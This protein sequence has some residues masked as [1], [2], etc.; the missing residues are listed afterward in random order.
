MGGRWALPVITAGGSVSWSGE[1]GIR[2]R[3]RVLSLHRFS[4]PALSATQPP[5]QTPCFPRFSAF[6]ENRLF[7][8]LLPSLL[9]LQLRVVKLPPAAAIRQGRRHLNL[10]AEEVTPCLLSLLERAAPVKLR[11]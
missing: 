10:N 1:G 3:G 7:S 6:L 2:T 11:I 8:S 4:K 9:P 5:L